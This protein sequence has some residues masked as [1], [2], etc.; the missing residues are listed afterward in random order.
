MRRALMVFL[1]LF[2]ILLLLTV[3]TRAQQAVLPIGVKYGQHADTAV[4]V[5]QAVEEEPL[6]ESQT[7]N[8]T[9]VDK[10]AELEKLLIVE[11]SAN[12]LELPTAITL[13]TIT[14][15][16][17]TDNLAIGIAAA[18]ETE[19]TSNLVLK[20]RPE[21]LNEAVEAEGSE[22]NNIENADQSQSISL[23]VL[24]SE[25]SLSE[26]TATNITL[27]DTTDVE[28]SWSNDSKNEV[29][30]ESASSE[31]SSQSNDAEI[32]ENPV[33]TT[34]VSA[35][36]SE[37]A[38][39]TLVDAEV[40]TGNPA[41]SS[42]PEETEVSTS[43]S[44]TVVTEAPVENNT[45]KTSELETTNVDTTTSDRTTTTP[46]AT[47]AAPCTEPGTQAVANDCRAYI[48]CTTT[49]TNELVKVQ[50]LCPIGQA[51]N[52]ALLR[53]SR[54]LSPCADAFRCELEGT[55]AVPR[56]NS[57]Y[58]WCVASRLTASFHIYQIKCGNGQIFTHE[59]GKCFVDMSNLQDLPLNYELYMSKSADEECVSEEVKLLRAEEKAKLKE[60]KLREKIR[61][62]Y[63]KELL[64]KAAKEAKAQAKLQGISLEDETPYNCQAEGNFA[65]ADESFFDYYIC[66]SKKGTYK[67]IG[68]KCAD[69]QQFS[70]AQNICVS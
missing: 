64:K 22:A 62:K 60:A 54:D 19:E 57:S 8:R 30:L 46:A 56:D 18:S 9:T 35:E 53:C 66:Q 20:E 17:K 10:P 32:I 26:D 42:V 28:S 65:A 70:T 13:E 31:A 59:L 27:E 34:T 52:P 2:S 38:Y 12:G 50:K 63:E 1:L 40:T 14:V 51:Y 49:A 5:E 7:T 41:A 24:Q 36:E 44:E 3:R 43:Q 47:T 45:D 23:A 67:P 11:D 39:T 58:Y 37:P 25:E 15:V 21:L 29:E 61:K 4:V 48:S 33:I 69:G 55:Y 16:E 6:I 68:M